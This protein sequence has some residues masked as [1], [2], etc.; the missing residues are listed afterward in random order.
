MALPGYNV[1]VLSASTGVAM[2]AEATTTSDNQSYQITNTSKQILDLNTAV[3]VDDGGTP[4]TESYTVDYLN[5]IVTFGTVDA[6]R[7]IT[8][9][10]A[11]LVPSTVATADSFTVS[12]T[13]DALNNTPFNTRF[14]TFQ[15][16]LASGTM[17]LGRFHVADSLFINDI[18]NNK[19]KIIKINVNATYSIKAYGLLTSDDTSAD[20]AD[21]IKESMTYQ[22][23][24]QITA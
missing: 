19:Y 23:T 10:G 20:V 7:V 14:M 1:E 6:G 8:I 21:L 13:A 18:L 17:N 3:V 11:Y 16:G 2:T 4:T 9:D 5:G 24:N 12:I 15:Q 22:I